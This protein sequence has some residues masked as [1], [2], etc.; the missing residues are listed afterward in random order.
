MYTSRKVVFI[1]SSKVSFLAR[2]EWIPRGNLD[3]IVGSS[4]N[5]IR[6]R[7]LEALIHISAFS[8]RKLTPVLGILLAMFM[9]MLMLAEFPVPRSRLIVPLVPEG[10]H[11]ISKLVPNPS[12]P[13]LKRRG[14]T[15]NYHL[16]SRRRSNR[17]KTSVTG[18]K[19]NVHCLE[20]ERP[21]RQQEAKERRQS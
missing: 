19:A 15:S 21:R 10:V 4:G 6:N 11:S 12:M 8:A 7:P 14:N 20:R 13:S 17:L 16:S 2:I 18:N 3:S 9:T 1:C 5:G